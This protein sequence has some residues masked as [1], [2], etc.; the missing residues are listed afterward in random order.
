MCTNRLAD[1]R[2]CHRG[3][4]WITGRYMDEDEGSRHHED[5]DNSYLEETAE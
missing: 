2:I 5:D 3:G 1:V 4:E